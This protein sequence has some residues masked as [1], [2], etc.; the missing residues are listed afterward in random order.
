[1]KKLLL[2]IM[3]LVFV[4]P[5]F[6]NNDCSSSVIVGYKVVANSVFKFAVDEQTAC[7]FAFYTANP[8][9]VVDAKGN[10]NLGEAIWYGYYLISKPNRI[11]EFSK[12]S[13][14]DWSAVCSI[15]AISFRD[16]NG[17][18]KSD[19]TI[20]SSC[21]KNT[22]N[23]SIPI[24]FIRTGKKYVLHEAV[25]KNLYGHL[26]LTVD[27]VSA[28]IKSQKLSANELKKYLE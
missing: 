23:Y 1:V 8:D 17:D 12:P 22:M 21:N 2:E 15:D 9:P 27:D 20:I 10:G 13:D 7:F 6:A 26:G 4:L 3:M 19:V 24:V 28:Y 11:Y 25:Y 18:K 14:L 16:M 5:A